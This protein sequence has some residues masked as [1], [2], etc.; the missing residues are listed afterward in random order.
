MIADRLL[1]RFQ[2]VQLLAGRWQGFFL[3]GKFKVLSLLG[4][5]GSGRVYLCEQL[6]LERL[7]AVKVLPIVSSDDA[8][9]VDHAERLHRELADID[10]LTAAVDLAESNLI[11]G[12][13]LSVKGVPF[14]Q[15]RDVFRQRSL[16]TI[17]GRPHLVA[18]R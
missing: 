18:R 4:A 8:G 13:F 11:V 3:L 12:R 16:E 14:A 9:S 17:F 7:V 15:A 5:G 10:G 1:T 2:A 6:R